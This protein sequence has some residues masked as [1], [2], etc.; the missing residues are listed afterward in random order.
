MMNVHCLHSEALVVPTAA[1]R[2]CELSVIHSW[3]LG[4][5]LDVPLG[6]VY[7]GDYSL[8]ELFEVELGISVQVKAADHSDDTLVASG[9]PHLA[10][11]SLKVFV[12]NVLVV[13]VIDLSEESLKVKIVPR[14]QLLLDLLLPLG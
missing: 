6:K 2:E 11:I 4:A 12:V 1:R 5:I 14:I 8:A 7:L 9:D 10:E 13:P 3:F